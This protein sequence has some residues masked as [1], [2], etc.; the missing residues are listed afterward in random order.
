MTKRRISDSD[1]GFPYDSDIDLME[2]MLRSLASGEK[3]KGVLYKEF[4]KTPVPTKS[5]TMRLMEFC[6]FVAFNG[7][8][9]RLTTFGQR[10]VNSGSL[11]KKAA[12]LMEAMPEYYKIMLS[13]FVN[14]ETGLKLEEVSDNMLR[15][16][17]SVLATKVKFSAR[18]FLLLMR[19]YKAISFVG[20]KVNIY[21]ITQLGKDL[22]EKKYDAGRTEIVIEP[23]QTITNHDTKDVFP[24]RVITRERSFDWDIKSEADWKVIDSVIESIKHNWKEKKNTENDK[25]L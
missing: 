22:V 14:N 18:T 21:Q 2:N 20:G 19:K 7:D 9:V 25:P 15:T 13:W 8:S 11:E 17:D 4:P 3:S 6:S 16:W 5:Y 12:I 10:F 1:I 24:I 23:K